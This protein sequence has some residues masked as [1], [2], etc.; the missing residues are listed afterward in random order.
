MYVIM[1]EGFLVVSPTQWRYEMRIRDTMSGAEDFGGVTVTREWANGW[2]FDPKAQ[3]AIRHLRRQLGDT[4]HKQIRGL[5]YDPKLE[6]EINGKASD[7]QFVH[8]LV[9]LAH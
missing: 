9:K 4:I 3:D 6:L 2:F 1:G 7:A 8:E 5:P